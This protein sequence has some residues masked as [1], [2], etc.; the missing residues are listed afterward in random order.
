MDLGDDD[1]G[2]FVAGQY[3]VGETPRNAETLNYMFMVHESFATFD[4]Y[5]FCLNRAF[6]EILKL[7][8]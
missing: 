2:Q 8:I 7:G 1:A 5:K 4:K 3:I 6:P